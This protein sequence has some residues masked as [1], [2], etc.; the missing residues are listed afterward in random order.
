MNIIS[1]GLISLDPADEVVSVT[2][3]Q[4]FLIVVTRQGQIYKVEFG[5]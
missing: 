4:D 2:Y 5:R 3:F 1:L